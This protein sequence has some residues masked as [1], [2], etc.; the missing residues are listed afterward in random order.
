VSRLFVNGT[1]AQ[2]GCYSRWF[3]LTWGDWQWHDV[4]YWQTDRLMNRHCSYENYS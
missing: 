2:L 4:S 1:S 3:T